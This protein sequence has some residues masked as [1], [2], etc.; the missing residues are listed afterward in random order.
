[1]NFDLFEIALRRGLGRALTFLNH[2]PS[3]EVRESVLRVLLKSSR[4]D[5]QM[6][7]VGSVYLLEAARRCGLQEDLT[8]RLVTALKAELAAAENFPTIEQLLDLLG[9][10]GQHGDEQ[11]RQTL[12]DLVPVFVQHHW[13]HL[14]DLAAALTEAL[15]E[16]GLKSIL[17]AVGAALMSGQE[18][19]KDDFL[20]FVVGQ[21]LGEDT[22]TLIERWTQEDPGIRLF[23]QQ[24]RAART[25]WNIRDL[26]PP[27]IDASY[28]GIWKKLRE[29]RSQGLSY[30]GE[31]ASEE[32]LI[33]LAW[34]LELEMDPSMKAL[35]LCVF[36]RTPFPHGPG[37]LLTL[38][39]H[40]Y[41]QVKQKALR[42]LAGFEGEEIHELALQTL[43]EPAS[44]FEGIK[45]LM[46]NFRSG[47]EKWIRTALE[48]VSQWG[49]EHHLHDFVRALQGL[50]NRWPESAMLDLLTEAFPQQPC[51]FCRETIFGVLEEH[52][53]LPVE[54]I[55]EASLDRNMD[56]REKAAQHLGGGPE[57]V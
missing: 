55:H 16:V 13:H 9:A 23:L 38:L 31:K 19:L 17:G 8:P 50:V 44:G 54:L 27:P 12:L 18:A 22:E 46:K 7:K 21:I 30:R 24:S 20:L 25:R 10:Q 11:A 39:D 28:E 47:D 35:L 37:P 51:S 2:P 33:R 42:A 56:L 36:H 29:G 57:G 32:T 15:G 14:P 40:P 45:L 5:P 48:Q 1:M 49:D 6:E 53:H 4:L 52:D 34:D 26:N 3:F 43:L 41:H